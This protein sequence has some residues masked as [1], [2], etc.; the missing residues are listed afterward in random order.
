MG[1]FV[2]GCGEDPIVIFRVTS[3]EAGTTA[4]IQVCEPGTTC[5]GEL[6]QVLTA[7]DRSADG[8]LFDVPA[9]VIEVPVQ[10]TQG[11]AVAAGCSRRIVSLAETPVEL[12]IKVGDA[13]PDIDCP[14][15]VCAAVEGCCSN[16]GICLP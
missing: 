1:V 3:T 13:A 9:G 14:T 4:S 2:A 5:T 8:A 15:G 10:V 16:L 6:A 11:G 12:A 7:D